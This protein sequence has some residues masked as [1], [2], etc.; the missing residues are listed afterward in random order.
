MNK[1]SKVTREK[2]EDELTDLRIELVRDNLY[3]AARGEFHLPLVDDISDEDLINE[4]REFFMYGIHD[5]E[6]NDDEVVKLIKEAIIEI[7]MHNFLTIDTK[8]N[9]DLPI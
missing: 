1:L 3:E 2:L 7:D 8:T 9:P 5:E 4:L 6:N